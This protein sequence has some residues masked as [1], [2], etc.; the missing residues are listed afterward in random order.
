[1]SA[2]RAG[3][4]VGHSRPCGRYRRRLVW[5]VASVVVALGL[6]VATVAPAMA[7]YRYDCS[8]LPESHV[9]ATFP[10][11]RYAGGVIGS[12]TLV[13][14]V[15]GDRGGFGLDHIVGDDLSTGD[16]SQDEWHFGGYM[17]DYEAYAIAKTLQGVPIVQGGGNWRYESDVP[18]F[19]NKTGAQ[20]GSQHFVVVLDPVLFSPPTIKTAYA[21][22]EDI[23]YITHTYYKLDGWTRPAD[24]A[25]LVK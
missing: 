24:W 8:G 10:L 20:I 23:R 19:S 16:P 21:N 14:G 1:M 11:V 22:P 9:V 12:A 13:C 4:R 2:H 5:L 17:S 15:E 6:S 7:R 3:I 25:S 18:I